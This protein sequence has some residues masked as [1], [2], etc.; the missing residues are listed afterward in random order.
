MTLKGSR[1]NLD[2][3]INK[4]GQDILLLWVNL[5]YGSKINPFRYI[6]FLYV[7]YIM[8]IYRF[9]KDYN[10]ESIIVEPKEIKSLSKDYVYYEKIQGKVKPFFDI[11][12]YDIKYEMLDYMNYYTSLFQ[13]IFQNGDLAISLSHKHSNGKY[14]KLSFHYV[15]NNYEYELNEFHEFVMNHPILSMDDNID[16]TIYKKRP[17]HYKVNFLGHNPIYFRLVLSYK[18][19]EDKRVKCPYNYNSNL[20]K[21]C[22]TLT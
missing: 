7:I 11:D 19:H 8:I 21:H 13:L 6:P 9:D 17:Q 12:I 2:P 20:E 18:S 1:S 14:E 10:C 3:T 16:K 5:T 22:I 4:V 15:I